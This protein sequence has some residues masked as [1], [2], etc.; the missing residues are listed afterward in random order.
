MNRDERRAQVLEAAKNVF[1]AKGY[2]G[3]TMNEIAKTAC[4]NKPSLYQIFSSKREVYL[5]LFDVHLKVLTHLVT[6]ALSSTTDNRERIR[7]LILG[8]Y[9]FVDSNDGA[10]RLLFESGLTNDPVLSARLETFNSAFAGAIER[11]IAEDGQLATLESRLLSRG[12]TGLTQMSAGYWIRARGSL[13]IEGATD[14]I[15]RLALLGISRFPEQTSLLE[16]K[17]DIP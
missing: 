1:A 17:Q 4:V 10:Y 12:L 11:T 2:Y 7:A 9:R 16:P 8:F 15:Y 6:E 14:L 13:D 5:A 3:A